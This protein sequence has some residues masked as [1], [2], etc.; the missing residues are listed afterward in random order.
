MTLLLS[1]IIQTCFCFFIACLLLDDTTAFNHYIAVVF[2]AA[3]KVLL[4]Y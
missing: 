2:L 3:L 1:I 4:A